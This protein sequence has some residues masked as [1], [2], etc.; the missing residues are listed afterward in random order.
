VG[1]I[2]N[3]ALLMWG[4]VFEDFLDDIGW[5]V[6]EFCERMTGGWCFGYAEA[7]ARKGI[8]V[9]MVCVVRSVKRPER[10]IHG[11]TGMTIILLPA[12]RWL[13]LSRRFLRIRYRYL[14][15]DATPRVPLLPRLAYHILPYLATPRR[16]LKQMLV[17]ERCD[18]LMNQSYED[19]RFDIAVRVGRQ[20]GIPVFVTAQGGEFHRSRLERFLRPRSLAHTAGVIIAS[21]TEAQRV[22]RDYGLEASK[23]ARVMNPIDDSLWFPERRQ[24]TRDALGVPE[25][26]LLVVWHGR[27]D[28]PQ[29]GIDVLLDAWGI[30]RSRMADQPPH[31]LLIGSGPHNEAL[32]ERLRTLDDAGIMW[33]DEYIGDR[34]Q[35]RRFLSSADLY[36]FPSR[37]EGQPSAPLEAMAC[38]LPV[39]AADA[40]GV[41]DIFQDGEASGGVLVPRGNTPALAD[42]M[43][44][45]LGDPARRRRL[46]TRA[47]ARVADAFSLE[48]VGSGLAAAL[49]SGLP[50]TTN[51]S[52]SV[53][54]DMAGDRQRPLVSVVII[55][56]NMDTGFFQEAIESVLGQRYDNWELFLVDDGTTDSSRDVA[57]RYAREHP[58]KIRYL[59]HDG[60][61][62]RGMSATRNLGARHAAGKYI[63]FLDADDLWLPHKL[64]NQVAVLEAHPEAAMVYGRTWVWHSWTGD[65]E[66]EAYD[67]AR[68]L[69]VEPDTLVEPPTLAR[70]FLQ[71]KAQTPIHCGVLMRR[72]LLKEVGGFEESF[73]G[74]NDSLYEDIVFYYKV[75]LNE[76]VFVQGECVD[77]YRRHLNSACHVAE[78]L[79]HYDPYNPHPAQL[80][81]LN[82]LE[83]YLEEQGFDDPEI[84]QAL[85]IAL[86]PYRQPAG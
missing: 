48:A 3:V 45:L 80:N 13:R 11:P 21:R 78:S 85:G 32:R 38:G 61:Q 66:H 17:R 18:A 42:A 53:R 56:F 43:V 8:E 55:F 68:N 65:P 75:C 28:F 22:M 31:L 59:E 37:G 35:M 46:A 52:R 16:A 2:R 5:T 58:D 25:D 62:N 15:G 47:Q 82:W 33:I 26:A 83:K 44:G 64:E 71:G 74:T 70:L 54:P 14:A 1:Q 86:L 39:V 9:V 30:V 81:F 27:I 50:S 34:S 60:H 79:G 24:E 4:D 76:C 23:I 84:W 67:R 73:R 12:T 77:R 49:E 69:G 40:N 20:V 19:P 57:L 10:R 29:K 7:L 63:A 36:V 41:P 72:Q 6:D 51:I